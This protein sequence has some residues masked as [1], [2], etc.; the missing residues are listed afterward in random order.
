M[1]RQNNEDTIYP[2]TNTTDCI[3]SHKG[4]G[5]GSFLWCGCNWD[6]SCFGV[7]FK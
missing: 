5:E 1:R 3:D 6:N 7:C 4:I 2:F